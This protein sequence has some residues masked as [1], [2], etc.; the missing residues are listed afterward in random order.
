MAS[1]VI[2]FVGYALGLFTLVFFMSDEETENT[3][4]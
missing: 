4:K 2:F 3:N 1:V